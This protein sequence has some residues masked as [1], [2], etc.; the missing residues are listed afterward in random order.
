M[1]KYAWTCR[2]YLLVAERDRNS[3]LTE[4]SRPEEISSAC[5]LSD[6][7]PPPGSPVDWHFVDSCLNQ[8]YLSVTSIMVS[9]SFS[10]LTLTPFQHLT[11]HDNRGPNALLHKYRSFLQLLCEDSATKCFPAEPWMHRNLP[12]SPS[13]ITNLALVFICARG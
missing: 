4:T 2:S 5:H 12:T 7:V 6:T 9:N 11:I 8:E 13:P 10:L 1:F 3:V